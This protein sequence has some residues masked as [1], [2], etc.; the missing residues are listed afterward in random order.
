[1]NLECEPCWDDCPHYM[2]CHEIDDRDERQEDKSLE[3]KRQKN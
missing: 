2:Q 1:M 3:W